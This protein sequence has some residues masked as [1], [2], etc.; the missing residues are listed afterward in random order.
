MDNVVGTVL[1]VVFCGVI[2]SA[3]IV[4]GY[5]AWSW[6]RRHLARSR[7]LRADA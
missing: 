6:L 1:A 4:V 3:V 7:A 2:V 5:L